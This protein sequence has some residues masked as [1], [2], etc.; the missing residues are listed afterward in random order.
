MGTILDS[1]PEA[2]SLFGKLERAPRVP[3]PLV[4]PSGLRAHRVRWNGCRWRCLE[5]ARAFDSKNPRGSCA[6][7][8][9]SM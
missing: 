6:A 2:R 3:R 8:T 9:P 5:C 7:L 1:L 4:L